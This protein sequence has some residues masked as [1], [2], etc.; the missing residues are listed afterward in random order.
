[1]IVALK[2]A[3]GGNFHKQSYYIINWIVMTDRKSH[4]NVKRIKFFALEKLPRDSL[5]R[6]VL[7]IEED[8]M[9]TEVFWLK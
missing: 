3:D 2:G 8:E 5:L 7:L 4:V 1:L 6:D 9:T